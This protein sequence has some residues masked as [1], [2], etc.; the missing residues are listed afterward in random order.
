[1]SLD[2]L[3]W[4]EYTTLAVAALGA[5][6]GIINTWN[7]LNQRRVRLKVRPGIAL[8]VTYTGDLGPEMGCIEV[9]NLSTFPV[10]LREVGFEI[11]GLPRKKARMPIRQPIMLDGGTWPRRVEARASVS[12][13]FQRNGL[14]RRF[15]RAYVVTECGEVGYGNSPALK[16][17]IR[18]LSS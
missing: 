17:M 7:A 9:T 16:S 6:L 3:S 10:T 1:M 11:R 13:F 12:V 18:R 15:G 14:E 8:P 5:G 4:K 2:S